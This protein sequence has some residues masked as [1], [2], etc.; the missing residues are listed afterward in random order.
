MR[1]NSI[2]VWHRIL[3]SIAQLQSEVGFHLSVTWLKTSAKF[4]RFNSFN[5]QSH[6]LRSFQKNVP[7]ITWK[8]PTSTRQE[9]LISSHVNSFWDMIRVSWELW[10]SQDTGGFI[11]ATYPTFHSLSVGLSDVS[12]PLGKEPCSSCSHVFSNEWNVEYV[13]W[14]VLF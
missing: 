3:K 4:E 11:E 12:D 2:N 1:L 6:S 5:P 7:C 9:P 10:I 8:G 13:E 14:N